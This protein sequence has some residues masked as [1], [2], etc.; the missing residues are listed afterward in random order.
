MEQIYRVVATLVR[1]TNT[2]LGQKVL[3]HL[4]N[5][6]YDE[7]ATLRIHPQHYTSADE[8]FI[9]ACI[10]GLVRKNADLPTSFDKEEAAVASFW[11][12]ERRCK[13]TNERLK[14]LMVQTFDYNIDDCRILD[15]VDLIRDIIHNVLGAAPEISSLEGCFG[16][17]SNVGTVDQ[18][19][20]VPD[21]ISGKPTMTAN[22]FCV[23]NNWAETAWGV[24][25]LAIGEQPIFVRGNRFATVPKDATKKRGVAP[26][27][28][29]NGF[30]QRALGISI[31]DRLK[32]MAGIDIQN[33]EQIHRKLAQRGSVTGDIA[34]IDCSNA[35][36]TLCYNLVRL[37]LPGDWFSLLDSLRSPFTLVNKKWVRL[38]KFS[39]MGNGYTFEL[40]TLIFWAI[41]KSVCISF[42]IRKR[43]YA[44]G[45]DMII[46]TETSRAVI[47]VLQFFGFEINR[48]KTF[49]S[50]PFRESCG[51]D[52]FNGML[53]TPYYLEN[54]P[55][56][57]HEYI[58]M[59]NG[60]RRAGCQGN[61]S[62][63]L[64]TR[65]V[66]TWLR[67]ISYIPSAAKLY[68]PTYLGDIVIH[69]PEEW[70]I[71]K[72][73]LGITAVKTW[74]PL[75][76]REL[77]WERWDWDTVVASMLYGCRSTDGILIPRGTPLSYGPRMVP[78]LPKATLYYKTV[79]EHF[80]GGVG[81]LLSKE[82][83]EVA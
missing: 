24:R 72:R 48:N 15:H 2:P 46:P 54:N 5:K 59:A 51:G 1:D 38:E 67:I 73:R 27:P 20:L 41:C 57:P 78:R 66:C 23:L 56:E 79:A 4:K 52:Y 63:Y 83:A 44:Y 28:V 9:D 69:A 11:S 40:E 10:A 81:K 62:D 6:E 8:Y 65:F 43:C 49:V 13:A 35:S 61:H 71:K 26:E 47:A 3:S 82:Y 14:R 39:S 55:N 29:I 21:K 80:S 18:R 22:A 17:G 31:R 19:T 60:L 7:L 74:S 70:W 64:D 53:V 30:Y 12:S 50:G 25:T 33:G 36:D 42:G 58:A 77:P 37:L 34:T 68:G 16:G 75:S 45:D 76:F 32:Q